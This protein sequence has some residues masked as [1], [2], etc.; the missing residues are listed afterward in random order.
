MSMLLLA[1][2]QI[3]QLPTVSLTLSFYS[4]SNSSL[5]LLAFL[6]LAVSIYLTRSPFPEVLLIYCLRPACFF[7]I[8]SPVTA[9]TLQAGNNGYLLFVHLSVLL[10]DI[11]IWFFN[12]RLH[13]IHQGPRPSALEI[14]TLLIQYI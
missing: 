10:L 2:S 14:V 8:D 12:Q 6:F 4:F 11:F 1:H 9:R 13:P 5:F 7:S 3:P